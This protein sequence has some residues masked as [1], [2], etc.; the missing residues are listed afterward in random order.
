MIVKREELADILGLSG[1][2]INKLVKDGMPRISHGKYDLA[3][4]VQW[5][6][7]TWRDKARGEGVRNIEEEKKAQIIAQTK[8]TELETDILKGEVIPVEDFVKVVNNI[9]M[10]T[11]TGIDSVAARATPIIVSL[12]GIEATAQG[13]RGVFQVLNE[14]SITIR[15]SI[16]AEIRN[17]SDHFDSESD[18]KPTPETKRVRVGGR[19]KNTTT[20]KPRARAVPK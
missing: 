17:Y 6:I 13:E 1:V 7:K 12:E 10:L 9:A 18:Y 4:A 8:K 14:E 16:A 11:A 19:K 2:M 20:R 15:E 3:A 5:Y